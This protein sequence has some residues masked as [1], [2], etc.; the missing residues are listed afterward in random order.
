MICTSFKGIAMIFIILI[1]NMNI[2]TCI[3]SC[4][5]YLFIA[6]IFRFTLRNFQIS[7]KVPSVTQK[8]INGWHTSLYLYTASVY[9]DTLHNMISE[10]IEWGKNHRDKIRE[11]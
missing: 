1:Q 11:D 9:C 10:M 2:Y 6:K 7:T 3:C 4:W 5:H 8:R